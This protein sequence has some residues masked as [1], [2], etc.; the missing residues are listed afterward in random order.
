MNLPRTWQLKS[1]YA[2]PQAAEEDCERL[3]KEFAAISALLEREATASTIVRFDHATA[4]YKQVEAYLS[5]RLADSPQD[6]SVHALQ[7]RSSLLAAEGEKALFL[8]GYTLSLLD[9]PRFEALLK[10]P[11]L[12]NLSFF[13]RERRH[14]SSELLDKGR[15]KLI[16]ALSVDGYH[17]YWSLYRLIVSKMQITYEGKK[18]SVGQADNLLT[19][20]DRAVRQEAFSL[21]NA[22][23]AEQADLLAQILNYMAGF[24][25][26]VF[27]ERGWNDVLHEP[28]LNNRMQKSTLDAIWKAI[29]NKRHL[30]VRYLEDKAR[31]LG[32]EKLSWT[33]VY[34]PIGTTHTTL[35]YDEGATM[36]LDT[37]KQRHPQ[38]A[39]F[40]KTA[41]EKGWIES[42]DRP[43]K[44]AGGFCTSFPLTG[45]SRIFLTY[46]GTLD[47]VS[48]LA[49]ELGHAYHNECVRSLP[50]FAQDYKMNVA[51][52][53][54][55]LAEM[56][57]I[58]GAISK[59]AEDEKLVLID[60]KLQRAVAFLMNIYARFLF[61]TAFYAERKN[62]F[63]PPE[64]LSQLMVE[65]QQKAFGN[66]LADWNPYFWA[67]KL[68]FYITDV[69]FYNFPYTFGFLLSLGIYTRSARDSDFAHKVDLFL[70][71]SALFTVEELAKKHLGV[72]LTKTDFWESAIDSLI[73]DFETYSKQ[74]VRTQS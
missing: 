37:F 47:N 18:L 74:T 26:Q 71:D 42:E 36:V 24:R 39:A 6:P 69:Q 8:L 10:D 33:D 15:E 46:N 64:R 16:S 17:S 60:D 45:E 52:T 41:L 50:F 53:A 58:D 38:M 3:K 13:L 54:S 70:K 67:S 44:Q 55:T 73:P 11:K 14:I 48:T 28:L 23:W 72:D 21:L 5:C 34:A 57:V 30:L 49:H 32:V 31:L 2:S 35:S 19:S 1:I 40:A 51:E 9:A 43:G 59:A 62:G 12:A 63:V 4:A 68:H 61:E 20:P 56:M 66:A 25:L 7:A 22:A 27:A 29:E 65:A